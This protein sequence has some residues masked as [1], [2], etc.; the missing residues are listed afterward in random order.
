MLTESALQSYLKHTKRTITSAKYKIDDTYYDAEIERIVT[1]ENAPNT[2]E[3]YLLINPSIDTEVE[4]SEVCLYDTS[5]NLFLQ[6]VEEEGKR[7]TINPLQE[8]GIY[9]LTFEFEDREVA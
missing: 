7:L 1:P 3:V 8:G 5:G 9:V 2:M 4:I 6:N